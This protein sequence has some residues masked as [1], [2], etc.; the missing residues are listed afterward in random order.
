MSK[1]FTYWV[2]LALVA[3]LCTLITFTPVSAGRWM[4]RL[5]HRDACKPAA[6][7]CS[8][9]EC[10]PACIVVPACETPS[11][12]VASVPCAPATVSAC[13]SA[14]AE[15]ACPAVVSPAP[16][17]ETKT[18]TPSAS[19][20]PP[21]PTNTVKPLEV[22]PPPATPT[23]A[24]PVTPPAVD[25]VP[26]VVEPAVV[27]PA[28]VEPAVVEP[29]A[30]AP[31]A[32]P[33]MAPVEPE[34]AI[35]EPEPAAL[36]PDDAM[37]V[38]DAAA[39]AEVAEPVDLEPIMEE[40]AAVEPP[41]AE[42]DA[43]APIDDLFGE[44]AA[45]PAAGDAL[46]EPE[47]AP[48]VE[49]AVEPAAEPDMEAEP[50]ADLD[51][52]FGDEPA[53]AAADEPAMPDADPAAEPMADND[54]FG[55]PAP[56]AAAEEPAAPAENADAALDGLFDEEVKPEADPID[57]PAKDANE[58]D[59]EELFGKPIT[60]DSST[61]KGLDDT[62]PIDEPAVPNTA[63]KTKVSSPNDDDAALDALF[64]VGAAAPAPKFEGAEY[65][66][67]VDNTGAYSVNARLAVIF[68]DKVKLMKE[69]GSFTTVPLARLSEAD[70]GYVQW[71]ASS[72]TN[73]SAS[74][75]VKTD[76]SPTNAE[77]TR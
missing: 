66:Q 51:A 8:V 43:V 52:L 55:E 34:P 57:A 36:A 56:E 31:L 35:V 17:S 37:P 70:F 67:W 63:P 11:P 26:A 76:S 39:P 38:E 46:A 25:P 3:T 14:P 60:T 77:S 71:V 41:A 53:A 22:A 10:E 68:T 69:N 74:M 72:M 40:P 65:R 29:A 50:A 21:A 75:L 19:D 64:G 58:P 45:E 30:E 5:L 13:D 24:P 54:L 42:P 61:P 9:V 20:V 59:L 73:E 27:E 48:E 47:M 44:P 12:C 49:P 62:A 6:D 33:E 32:E 7:A 16:A 1:P 18:E 2:R 15:L 23:V 28:V 4:D